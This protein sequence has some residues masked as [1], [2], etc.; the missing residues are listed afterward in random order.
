M[1][2]EQTYNNW[3]A[4]LKEPDDSLF[5]YHPNLERILLGLAIFEIASRPLFQK[6]GKAEAL[7]ILPIYIVG[8]ISAWIDEDDESFETMFKATMPVAEA[9]V[10]GAQAFSKSYPSKERVIKRLAMFY[11]NAVAIA[12]DMNEAKA[13]ALLDDLSTDGNQLYSDKITGFG[14]DILFLTT[15]YGMDIPPTKLA[16]LMGW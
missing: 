16:L 13:I 4:S 8:L 15:Q 7:R 14:N 5:F 9:Y 2:I 1:T 6:L 12:G 3:R 11:A 10:I